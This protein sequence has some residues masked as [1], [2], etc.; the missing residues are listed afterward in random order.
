MTLVWRLLLHGLQYPHM[1]VFL[2]H[3]CVV[4]DCAAGFH[5]FCSQCSRMSAM[6]DTSGLAG[7]PPLLTQAQV[8]DYLGLKPTSVARYIKAGKL[9]R[10]RALGVVRIRRQDLEAFINDST[11]GPAR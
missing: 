2:L 9:R 7:L 6:S 3:R 8:A 11:E 1:L 5:Q 4:F 10:V